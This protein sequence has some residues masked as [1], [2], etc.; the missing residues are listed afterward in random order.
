MFNGGFQF[1]K[2]MFF[3]E[4]LFQQLLREF[5]CVEVGLF[6]FVCSLWQ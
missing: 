6:C 3:K 1:R 4:F 5:D 2:V